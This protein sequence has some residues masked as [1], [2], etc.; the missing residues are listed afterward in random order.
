MKLTNWFL[1]FDFAGRARRSH[2]WA[3]LGCWLL[4]ALGFLIVAGAMSKT[5]PGGAGGTL[6]GLLLFAAVICAGIDN[7]AMVFRRAHDTGK[8]GWIWLLL[9]IPFINLL[10]FY[11]LM[12]EDSQ[13]G[14]NK[15]G[16][17]VK[18]FYEPTASVAGS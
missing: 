18:Q 8:S 9:L 14:P 3:N 15:Y 6:V 2:Y 7:I 12:I 4:V 1:N 5:D 17:P 11:W 10:P 16:P 13:Q